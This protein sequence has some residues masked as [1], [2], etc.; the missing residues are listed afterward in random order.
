MNLD[1]ARDTNPA[2][3]DCQAVEAW[4]NGQP[5]V[6]HLTL[7]LLQGEST[8]VL[9]P[10]GA[11]KTTLVKLISRTLYPVVKPGSHLR[12]F[13][14]ESVNLWALRQRLGIVSSELEK[15]IPTSLTGRELLLAAFFGAIG[16]G[17]DRTPSPEQIAR[18]EELL[19][20]LDLDALAEEKYG[21][22]SEG[23]RR[24]LLIARALVHEPDVL[25]L[26]E[27]T[28]GL[29]LRAR[30]TLL[31]ALQVLCQQ[32]TTLVLVTHQVDAIIPEI[33]RVVGLKNCQVC[34]DGSTDQTLTGAMLSALFDTPLS[35]VQ[36]NGFRQVLPR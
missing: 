20:A 11:G 24:R 10:N 33:K 1:Q 28:N 19:I 22:L 31:R 2:W 21:Q 25:V 14:S 36:A 7:R 34:L 16:L 26:D 32:G 35:V 12:L 23:Q 15:R 8:A 5:V 9:G 4:I 29:D 27:P 17:R 18:T 30:H 6:K 13:G 3:L